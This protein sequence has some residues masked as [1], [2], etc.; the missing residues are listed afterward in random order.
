MDFLSIIL[1]LLFALLFAVFSAMLASQKNRNPI[2]WFFVGLF[3]GPFGLLVGAFSKLEE[4]RKTLIPW[5]RNPFICDLDV[6][7][8][9]RRNLNL[10]D[11]IL[12]KKFAPEDLAEKYSMSVE[13]VKAY[14][15]KMVNRAFVWTRSDHD[16]LFGIGVKKCPYCAETVQREATVCP[17]CRKD[18][19]ADKVA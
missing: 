18:I 15:E 12:S 7:T 3:T 5:W 1:L 10:R 13:D 2:A 16:K 19:L 8:E 4:Q 14:S 17:Y 11:N 6:L 9:S